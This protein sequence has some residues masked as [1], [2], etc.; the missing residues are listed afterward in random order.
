MRFFFRSRQFKVILTILIALITV[1]IIFSVMGSKISPQSNIVGT[2]TAP[3]RSAVTTI[4]NAFSDFFTAL[5][6]GN[7]IML[8]NTELEAQINNL[9]EQLAD[10]EKISKENDFYK[11]YLEIKDQNPD[12]KFAPATLIS[13]DN[14][15]P[16]KAFIINKGSADGI[17]AHDPVIT[18]AGLVGFVSEVG[19][20]TS[21]I[22]TILSPDLT[23][24]A[25]D[26][27]T[28]DSGII[29]GSLETNEKGF[30]KFKNLPH[31]CSVSV[32][33]YVVTSGEGVFPKGLLVGTIE[34]IANDKYNTSLYASVKPFVDI[35]EVRDVMVITEF[36]GQGSILDKNG[37]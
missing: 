3:I 35:D 34:T 17:S 11:D 37:E 7:E 19:L 10:Y 32:G 8:E 36:E 24:G 16:Y 6:D 29:S 14:S 9:R 26:N 18:D 2:V 27:R 15:D 23:L 12:F 28:N 20:T 4:S 1:S 31:S 13:R 21:K 25:L 33:D 5:S 22:A 30:T